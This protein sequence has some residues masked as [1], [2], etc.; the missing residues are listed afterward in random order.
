M[1]VLTF[2]YGMILPVLPILKRTKMSRQNNIA[3]GD[4]KQEEQRKDSLR[5]ARSPQER[6]PSSG[7][8][9]SRTDNTRVVRMDPRSMNDLYERSSI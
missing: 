2:K 1:F 7:F 5:V 9:R 6:G 4:R 3:R 8:D